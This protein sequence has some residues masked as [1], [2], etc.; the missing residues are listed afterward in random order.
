MRRGERL[1]DRAEKTQVRVLRS[2]ARP[3]LHLV[4]AWALPD[5]AK[6][7]AGIVGASGA[8]VVVVAEDGGPFEKAVAEF[9]AARVQRVA[10][11]EV[12][13]EEQ[14]A[15][16]REHLEADGWL[17][18]RGGALAASAGWKLLEGGAGSVLVVDVDSPLTEAAEVAQ[19]LG[20]AA[21]VKLPARARVG[22]I[23]TPQ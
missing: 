8:A 1:T 15:A 20:I 12:W 16:L 11:D 7:L 5:G 13:V 19:L 17:L 18:S 10:K 14:K 2:A 22:G 21:P 9:G 23:I 3:G 6:D 4:M